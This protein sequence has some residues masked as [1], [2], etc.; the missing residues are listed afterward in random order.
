MV[1]KRNT[2]PAGSDNTATDNKSK[3]GAAWYLGVHTR[4][5]PTMLRTVAARGVSLAMVNL[6]PGG[7]VL[8]QTYMYYN[9]CSFSCSC[10]S[11]QAM[12]A[13]KCGF[14]MCSTLCMTYILHLHIDMYT[15]CIMQSS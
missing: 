14:A 4:H 13:C 5:P 10:C 7:C 15:L 9:Y 6:D 3:Q 12:L 11:V 1:D 8:W 2:K